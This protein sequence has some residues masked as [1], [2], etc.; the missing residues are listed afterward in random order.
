[1]VRITDDPGGGGTPVKV[2][3]NGMSGRAR[4][5]VTLGTC[6]GPDED[7]APELSLSDEDDGSSGEDAGEAD[8]Y[9]DDDDDIYQEFEEFDFDSLPDLPPD[10]QSIASDDSFYPQDDSPENQGKSH[11][12]SQPIQESPESVSFFKACSNN[13]SIIVKIMIRQGLKEEEVKETDKNRRS[14]LMLACY[15]GYVDVVIALASCPYID[16]NWQDN[17]GNTALITAVQAGHVMISNYLLNYFPGLDLERRNC[18]G[19]TAMMKAAM[20]GRADCVRALM[21]AGGD[22]EARDYGRKMTPREWALFTGRYDT[23]AL[24]TRLMEQ[25]CAEQFCDAYRL[26]WPLLQEL[27]AQAQEPKSCWRRISQMAMDCCSFNLRTKTNALEDGVLDHTVRITTSL[28]SPLVAPVCRTVA[29]G[30]PPCVGKRRLAVQ[31]I[32][33]KQQAQQLQETVP[34]LPRAPGA[35]EDG[36]AV[37]PAA[38]GP[39]GHGRRMSASTVA[40]RRTSLLPLHLMRRSSVRP[41]M[42]VPKVRLCKAP[43]NANHL[44]KQRRS[45]ENSH[46]QIPKWNYKAI[47]EERRRAEE[48]RE[49]RAPT[50]RRR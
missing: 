2:Q 6:K 24:M 33:R 27:V 41:G 18:H 39:P 8:D 4:V 50:N 38:A 30:S 22:V 10:R 7:E 14:G 16:I 19:F 49:R 26:E 37:Q 20:Q 46:L 21:M 25:P 1:M 31:E 36:P 34:E 17:E 45:R 29:P 12:F 15:Q 43:A 32:L 5:G 35:Q 47:K 9:Y 23:A 28:V 11:L 13:N 42:V 3:L 48:D 40:L 44:E